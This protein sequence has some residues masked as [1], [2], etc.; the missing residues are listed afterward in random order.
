MAR[1]GLLASER[2]LQH[3]TGPYHPERPHRLEAIYEHLD[4]EGVLGEL[5]PVEPEPAALERVRAAHEEHHLQGLQGA[6]ALARREGT[7][8]P[9][10]PDTV[11]GP[12]SYDIALLAAGGTLRACD[13]VMAGEIDRAFCAV[14]PPGHHA[15]RDRTAGFC[16]LNNDAIAALHLLDGHGLERVLIVD[17][18][19]HHG[20]G[21]Q[22]ILEDDPRVYYMSIHQHP[23]FPGTGGADERGR[24]AGEGFTRNVPM[25]PGQGDEAYLEVFDRDFAPEV[26]RFRPEFILASAGFDAHRSDPLAHM[27]V[28][29]EG[30]AEMTRRVVAWAKEYCEGRVVS[31]LEGGYELDALAESVRVHLERLAD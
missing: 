23:L 18:D 20:N 12:S 25:R 5:V 1:V 31:L 2:F 16:L 15:E 10:D 14:R 11:C 30:F 28:T 19:V 13:A 21:T 8:I 26:E 22:H 29:T 7:P 27:D 4:R 9:T 3:D 17:W 6:Q 24:G